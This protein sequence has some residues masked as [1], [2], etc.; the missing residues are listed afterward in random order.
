[1]R[2]SGLCA[3]GGLISATTSISDAG[4]CSSPSTFTRE[5]KDAL[6]P[7]LQAHPAELDPLIEH[8]FDVMPAVYGASPNTGE[9]LTEVFYATTKKATLNRLCKNMLKAAQANA[10][11]CPGRF[12]RLE[13]LAAGI[14]RI[15]GHAQFALLQLFFGSLDHGL[16]LLG[17]HE[18]P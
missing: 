2:K 12:K 16:K 18:L 7:D 4:F 1:M 13:L 15:G 10:P 8:H 5:R 6:A 14:A 11:T 9:H 3:T 17:I